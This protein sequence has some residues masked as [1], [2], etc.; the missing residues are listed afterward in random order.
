MPAQSLTKF[1]PYEKYDLSWFPRWFI[2]IPVDFWLSNARII[3]EVIKKN[4]LKPVAAE[5]LYNEFVYGLGQV[6]RVAETASTRA[7]AR[8]LKLPFPFPG[9]IRVPHLHFKGDLF[10]LDKKQWD[11]FSKKVV[12]GLQQKL[13]DAHSVN[14]EQVVKL[15]EAIDVL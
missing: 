4:Q 9:G 1:Y 6:E 7:R 10:L 3:E 5:S 15:S 12:E 13:A 8:E 2:G 14:L 11:S